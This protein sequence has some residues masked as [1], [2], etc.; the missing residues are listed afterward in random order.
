MLILLS[1]LSKI[2]DKEDLP[3][4]AKP[5][6]RYPESDPYFG[7]YSE[8]NRAMQTV[9]FGRKKMEN[10]LDEVCQAM[11][12]DIGYE[13]LASKEELVEE[14]IR[15]IVI[16]VEYGDTSSIEGLLMMVPEKTLID[17]LPEE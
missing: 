6:F 8:E 2:T 1:F 13:K 17:F 3:E 9:G 12:K 15:L 4:K 10:S 7:F 5:Y 11:L 16:D 14:V